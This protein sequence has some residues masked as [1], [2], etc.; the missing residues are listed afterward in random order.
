[1]EREAEVAAAQLGAARGE[2]AALRAQLASER[3]A[4]QEELAAAEERG[5]WRRRALLGPQAWAAGGGAP[6]ESTGR[7]DPT[8]GSQEGI[9]SWESTGRRDPSSCESSSC[10]STRCDSMASFAEQ[11]C[12]YPPARLSVA[13]TMAVTLLWPLPWPLL[14]ALTNGRPFLWL[15]VTRRHHA[16]VA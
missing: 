14:T 10:E 11:T 8:R 5:E 12:S 9:P 3:A 13:D 1:M 2:A 7:W 4:L 6:R 15:Q 16:P